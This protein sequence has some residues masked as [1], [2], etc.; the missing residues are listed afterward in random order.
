M[1]LYIPIPGENAYK[2][3]QCQNDAY[4]T[5]AFECQTIA[6]RKIHIFIGFWCLCVHWVQSPLSRAMASV[7]VSVAQLVFDSGGGM[8]FR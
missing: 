3:F 6:T 1:S 5:L 2:Y 8:T 7:I 4:V